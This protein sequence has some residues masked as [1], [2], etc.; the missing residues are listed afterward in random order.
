[1]TDTSMGWVAR[2]HEWMLY[3]SAVLSFVA[4]SVSGAGLIVSALVAAGIVASW[5]AQRRG[6]SARVPT[7]V[8]NAIILSALALSA[9]WAFFSDASIIT[10]GIRFILTLLLLKLF[11]RRGARDDWQV[12][13]LSFLLM[14]AGTAVNEDLSYGIVF[15]VYVFVATLGLAIFHL[16]SETE[17]HHTAR[18][19]HTDLR[20][21]YTLSSLALAA[22]VFAASVLIFFT[23]PRVGLGFFATKTRAQTS[24]IGFS[25][26]VELGS[27]GLIRDNPAVAMRV[28]FP[29]NQMPPDAVSYHWRIM[30]FDAYDGAQWTREARPRRLVIPSV[31]KRRNRPSIPCHSTS[32]I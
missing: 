7:G 15:T 5:F 31:R 26:Q 29:D 10:V 8:W 2:R 17:R 9:A 25:D 20:R 4:V 16:R 14:S 24:M 27:H 21:L 6:W 11:S 18:A 23:F 19:R 3:A 28:Y 1:M 12:Y 32:A 22:S 13:A 30:S